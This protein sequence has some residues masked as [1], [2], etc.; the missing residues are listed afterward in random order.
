MVDIDDSSLQANSQPNT[1][2]GLRVG[3]R[4]ALFYIHQMNRM[5]S[6]NDHGHDDSTINVVLV[7][8]IIIIIII[9]ALNNY[10]S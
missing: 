7:I 2:L 6:R 8:I 4:L 3:G 9:I 10:C 1:R 5:N